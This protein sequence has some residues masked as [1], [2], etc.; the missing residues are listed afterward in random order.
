[1][2][3]NL[4]Q[5]PRAAHNSLPAFHYPATMRFAI[6]TAPQHTTWQEMLAVWQA[7]D[8][9]DLFESAWNFDH[10]YPTVA[11]TSGNCL[12]GWTTLTALAQATRRLRIGCMVLGIVYRHPAVLAN[13]AS[14]L[15]IV[16]GGRLVLGIGAAWN[17]EECDAY[18]I[19][20][21]S[22]TERF[23][24][25]EEACEVIHK[26]FTEERS[27]F[28]GRY[29]TLAD[30][31]NNPKGLQVPHPPICIGGAGEKRTLPLVAR[32]ADHW[33]FPGSDT[34]RFAA[35]RAILQEKCEEIGRDPNEI[36]TSMHVWVENDTPPSATA[37]TCA[38]FAEAGADLSICYLM[39]PLLPQTLEPLANSLRELADE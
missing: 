10:F 13:M 18:G 22:L 3:P 33:D 14:T 35:K 37:E 7:A 26:L 28:T 21:G 5:A 12:E 36:T 38:R 20:L 24:R 39:P 8:E 19:E 30:A 16:S 15:D 34:E 32:Y 2:S 31:F 17:T 23:D 29:F 4:P 25:F 11:P 1:M 27:T 9:I 6:K